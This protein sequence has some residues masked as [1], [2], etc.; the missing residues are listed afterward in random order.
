[1]SATGSGA[2]VTAGSAKNG[3]EKRG[4]DSRTAVVHTVLVGIDE[5]VFVGGGSGAVRSGVVFRASFQVVMQFPRT[6]SC[7][8][9]LSVEKKH[10]ESYHGGLVWELVMH[11][12]GHFCRGDSV[13]PK[14][15]LPAC[16]ATVHVTLFGVT[17]CT[18]CKKP[19]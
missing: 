7:R 3:D 19:G 6:R 13:D 1:M 9:N 15:V 12:D 2:G 14:K 10:L 16:P 4:D 8:L 18:I 17:I 5:L 11:H